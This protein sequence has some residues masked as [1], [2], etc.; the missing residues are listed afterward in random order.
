VPKHGAAAPDP[1]L[2]SLAVLVHEHFHALAETGADSDGLPSKGP[3]QSRAWSAASPVNE[4][5]AAWMECHALRKLGPLLSTP[6]QGARAEAA[7]WAYV[8]SGTYPAWPYRG[9]EQVESLYR[10]E[11]IAGV[12]RLVYQLRDAPAVAHEQFTMN[13]QR[14]AADQYDMWLR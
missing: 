9:A 10:Q 8:R 2:L 6:E 13:P 4:A 5:L 1:Q 12:R 11:G 7:V 14:A 3:L